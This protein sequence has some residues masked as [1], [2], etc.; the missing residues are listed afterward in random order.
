MKNYGFFGSKVFVMLC[1]K[2]DKRTKK[3]FV[4]I[5]SAKLQN[6]ICIVYAT[7][8]F[9]IQHSAIRQCCAIN[10]KP[11]FDGVALI[12][13][14]FETGSF[15]LRLLCNLNISVFFCAAQLCSSF[16][17]INCDWS[18]DQL[19]HSIDYLSTIR[20]TIDENHLLA[21][22]FEKFVSSM[23][24]PY[25]FFLPISMRVDILSVYSKT[26]CSYFPLC[27]AI[28]LVGLHL[29]SIFIWEIIFLATSNQ[30]KWSNWMWSVTTTSFTLEQLL[31]SFIFKW[32]TTLPARLYHHP[33]HSTQQFWLYDSDGACPSSFNSLLVVSWNSRNAINLLT[34][35]SYAHTIILMCFRFSSFCSM[36]FGLYITCRWNISNNACN[37]TKI[38]QFWLRSYR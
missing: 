32:K 25:L 30:I 38:Y 28:Y 29:K 19:I 33:S 26:D 4:N 23:F 37:S 11:S 24:R 20:G 18:F 36:N 31:L 14:L 17:W 13:Y 6:T 27:L 15:R 35:T 8:A 2:D 21:F 5:W 7:E 3:R 34:T 9:S 16:N 22:N 1:N 10:W 12:K